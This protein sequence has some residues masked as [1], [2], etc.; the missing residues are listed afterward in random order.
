MDVR[1]ILE[2]SPSLAVARPLVRQAL[3]D[4]GEPAT[5][6]DVEALISA[7]C[8]G[9]RQLRNARTGELLNRFA[10]KFAAELGLE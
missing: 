7:V 2:E 8:G 3:A 10:R 9:D 4:A 5:A 6:A 1:Q